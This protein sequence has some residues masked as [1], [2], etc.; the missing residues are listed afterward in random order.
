MAGIL[1]F[2]EGVSCNKVKV[3]VEPSEQ[4]TWRAR[5]ACAPSRS[6]PRSSRSFPPPRS[7]S[8]AQ[9]SF[10]LNPIHPPA[11]EELV[12]GRGNVPE[13][14][15]PGPRHK[16]V[17]HQPNLPGPGWSKWLGWAHRLEGKLLDL[18]LAHRRVDV[19][20]PLHHQLHSQ[21]LSNGQPLLDN[22][23]Q[24]RWEESHLRM[25]SP[26]HLVCQHSP[27]FCSVYHEGI[28]W[29]WCWWWWWRWWW[30]WWTWWERGTL[31]SPLK[32]KLGQDHPQRSDKAQSTLS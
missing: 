7:P 24:I 21:E 30:W 26:E 5:R 20:A 28:S 23:S 27:E 6:H 13:G 25:G 31:F 3:L 15:S 9:S 10:H 2:K 32:A 8:W 22:P 12:E 18:L 4:Q 17:P 19:E 29:S 1:S 14:E 16:G 11:P